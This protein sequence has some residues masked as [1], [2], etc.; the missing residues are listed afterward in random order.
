VVFGWDMHDAPYAK[1]DDLC[2]GDL[3]AVI[4]LGSFRRIPWENNM[5]FFLVDYCKASDSTPVEFCPRSMLKRVVDSIAKTLQAKAIAGIEFEWYNYLETPETL[6]E[7]Q[8]VGLKNL[9]PGMFGYSLT[10]T[11]QFQEY[12]ADL[13][14]LCFDFGI[15][16]EGI[17]TETGPGVYEVALKYGSAL[18]LSDRAQL[19]KTSAKQIGQLQP[20]LHNTS[21]VYPCFMA[22]HHADLPGCS[23]H[24]H[25]S[26]FDSKGNNLFYDDKDP[27]GMSELFRSFLAGILHC[28]PYVMPIYAPNVNSYKRYAGNFWA[29]LKVTFGLEDRTAAVRVISPKTS[30][31]AC[32]A[33]GTRAELRVPGADINVYLALSAAFAS[34]LYGIKEKI[35]LS[36][37][38]SKSESESLPNSLLEAINKMERSV[39]PTALFGERFT[40]HYLMTRKEEWQKWANAVTTWELTR[41]FETV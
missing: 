36:R 18:E 28:L 35:E 14:D 31:I 32:S 5:P 33:S 37:F 9:T 1:V 27:D 23:G 20:K 39:I 40:N 7:K 41:Y 11:T 15:E 24:I 13:Y 10:R 29:P 3:L 25:L 6:K 30:G 16:I 4:D 17:H 12:F 22:K 8:G 19:F 34:G 21:T 26:L 38:A 2:Y